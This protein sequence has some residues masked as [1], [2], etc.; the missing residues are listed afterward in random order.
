MALIE[1]DLEV[2]GAKR[3]RCSSLLGKNYS[4]MVGCITFLPLLFSAHVRQG[5]RSSQAVKVEPPT[6]TAHPQNYRV[7]NLS[8]D[9][10]EQQ[11]E[12]AVVKRPLNMMG[13]ELEKWYS[14][15]WYSTESRRPGAHLA[16]RDGHLGITPQIHGSQG[17][18]RTQP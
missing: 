18:W 13:D 7:F 12:G 10:D 16:S 1:F 6:A 2:R 15:C 17:F 14:W 9:L 8:A 3:R 5:R 11:A 4:S